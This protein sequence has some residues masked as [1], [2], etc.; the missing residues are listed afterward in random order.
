MTGATGTLG[1]ALVPAL[2]DRGDSVVALSR[3][4][5][6]ARERLGAGVEAVA[7]PDPK[8]QAAPT[9]AFIGVDAVVHLLGEPVAQRWTD[10]AR[11]EIRESRVAGTRNLVDALRGG[12]PRPRALISQSAIGYYG[13]HG[14]EPVDERT[15]AGADFLASVVVAWEAEARRAEELGMRVALMRTGVVLSGS[16]G[17][18]EKM[19]PP[20]KLG[21]GGPV[22]GGRQYVPWVHSDDVVGSIVFALDTDAACGPLNVTAPEPV[23]NREL[24][25][26]LG[27][28]LRRPAL[29]PVP[30]LALKLLYGE[31]GSIVTTGAR[32]VPRRLEELGYEFRRPDL[33]DALRAAVG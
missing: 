10:S 3:D 13:A 32:A 19:L 16:G 22:A 18:L 7:W 4:P 24:S 2:L 11:E 20:F 12:D 21:V 31:M 27:R 1:A 30:A 28:V 5:A 25:K 29:A 9:A 33:E 26:T 14:D 8:A 17:A 23:T 6:R 15:P